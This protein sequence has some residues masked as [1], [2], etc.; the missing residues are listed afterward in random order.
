MRKPIRRVFTLTKMAAHDGALLCYR[1]PAGRRIGNHD[2]EFI[3]P[4]DVPPFEGDT[5]EFEMERVPGTPWP[6]WVAVRRV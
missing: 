6:R 4:E 2:T 1:M 5:A 3:R